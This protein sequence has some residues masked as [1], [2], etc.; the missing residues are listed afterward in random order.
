MPTYRRTLD[1]EGVDTV[2]DLAVVGDEGVLHR[3]LDR[4]EGIGVTDL[5]ANLAA[6]DDGAVERTMAFLADQR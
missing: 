5:M 1:L 3:F 6:V 2:A 4:L